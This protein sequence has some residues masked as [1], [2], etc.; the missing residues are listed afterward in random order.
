MYT[1][2]LGYYGKLP[3]SPEFI[4]HRAAGPEIDELDQWLREGM[5][6]A[7]LIGGSS[8]STDFAQ[9]DAWS[10]LYFPRDPRR[11]LVGSLKPSRDKAGRDFPFVIYLFLNR[12]EFPG[13]PW[14]APM[15][16]KDFFQQSHRLLSQ[17]GIENDVARL[18]FRLQALAPV[19]DAQESSIE[20]QYQA[21]LVSRRMRDYW[22]EVLGEINVARIKTLFETLFQ[23]SAE[24]R[25]PG[26]HEATLPLFPLERQETYDVPFWVDVASRAWLST[27]DAGMMFWNRSPSKVK[28]LLLLSTEGATPETFYRLIHP[29]AWENGHHAPEGHGSKLSEAERALLE[30]KDVTLETF[31]TRLSALKGAC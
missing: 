13:R 24:P 5:Y 18:H 14:C 11:F 3:L 22:I 15:Q 27:M 6:H 30:D 26:R 2:T 25:L 31:L 23:P 28:P 29:E 4:H 17:V 16:F 8:W 12:E 7:K 21:E 10:F 20:T 19:E 1:W 9:A